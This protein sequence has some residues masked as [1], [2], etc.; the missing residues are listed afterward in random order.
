MLQLWA[1]AAKR[2]A[3]WPPRYDNYTTAAV[4]S[5]TRVREGYFEVRWRSGSS[6]I[7]SSWWLHDNSGKTTWTE[8]D[9]FETS[10]ASNGK[11]AN[12]STLPS[13][14][15]IFDLPKTTADE[16]PKK[17][18]C[19]L[20]HSKS[21][22]VRCSLG[23]IFALDKAQPTFADRF[24]TANLNWT[25]SG[26]AI[27]LDGALV[28]VITSPCLVQQIGMDFDR[29]TMPGWMAL[30]DPSTLPDQPFEIDYVRAWRRAR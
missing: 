20:Y 28:N 15:H 5:L 21:G 24:Y 1:H 4:H 14:V 19:K 26:V 23:S 30:P 6:G 10:G 9:V 12:A 25:N 22:R 8:I 27:R 18:K 17:C 11:Q 29:E 7:S 16:L 2:N 13:H 3:S